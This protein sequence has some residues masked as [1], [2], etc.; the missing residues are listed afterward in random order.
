M[1]SKAIKRIINKDIK[2][3]NKLNLNEQGIY[4]NFN[5]ENILEANL[6]MQSY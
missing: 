5:E 4:I 6:T 3:I 1:S 2:D